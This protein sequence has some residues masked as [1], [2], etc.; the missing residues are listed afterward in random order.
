LAY[1]KSYRLVLE[2]YKLTAGFPGSEQFGLTSQMRRSAASIPCN[3]AEGWAR[4]SR[5]YVHFLRVACGSAAELQTQ[6]L[7]ARDLG[8]CGD[9]TFAEAMPRLEEV[10]KLL[11]SYIA[12]LAPQSHAVREDSPLYHLDDT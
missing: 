4:G 2:I 7:V 3:I 10:I 8:Y 12:K 6:L 9:K 1:Q 11:R 5:E